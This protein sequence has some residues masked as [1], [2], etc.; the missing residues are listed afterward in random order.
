M[1]TL[2][3]Q[4]SFR[5]QATCPLPYA[6]KLQAALRR[7]GIVEEAI[8]DINENLCRFSIICNNIQDA[9]FIDNI[10]KRVVI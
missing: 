6:E 10:V 2:N 5:L 4:N 8:E 7:C 9:A 1:I 3:I